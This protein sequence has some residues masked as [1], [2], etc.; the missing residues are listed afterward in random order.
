MCVIEE[1]YM[2]NN[3]CFNVNIWKVHRG[4]EFMGHLT[5]GTIPTTTN[6]ILQL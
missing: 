3:N 4:K 1:L 2:I 6:T 5:E